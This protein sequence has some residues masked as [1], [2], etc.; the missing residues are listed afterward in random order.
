MTND[1]NQIVESFIKDF[2][3]FESSFREATEEKDL[4]FGPAARGCIA[5]AHR[6]LLEAQECLTLADNN[7]TS[8][9]G[10]TDQSKVS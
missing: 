3:S 10:Q 4:R 5:K 1:P 8:K 2:E 7:G 6:Y 9:P